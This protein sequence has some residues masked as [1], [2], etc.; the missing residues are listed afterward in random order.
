MNPSP[1]R[2]YQRFAHEPCGKVATS[3]GTARRPK[4]PAPAS[5]LP[6]SSPSFCRC[7]TEA[8]NGHIWSVALQQVHE[9]L[10]LL[11]RGRALL[12]GLPRQ[13]HTPAPKNAP[14]ALGLTVV[15]RGDG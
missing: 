6:I 2:G 7:F 3:A 10:G 15:S 9:H 5:R 11:P 12:L 13:Q 14:K 4:R 8:L 1:I